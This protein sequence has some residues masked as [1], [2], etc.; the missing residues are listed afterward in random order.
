MISHRGVDRIDLLDFYI[1]PLP[2]AGAEA[3]GRDS[4]AAD[5]TS[6]LD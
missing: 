1:A 4:V 3:A 5:R 6:E 2:L